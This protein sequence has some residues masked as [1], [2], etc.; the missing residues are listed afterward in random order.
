MDKK[1]RKMNKN[2]YSAF[3]EINFITVNHGVQFCVK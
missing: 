3:L 1:K 2:Y